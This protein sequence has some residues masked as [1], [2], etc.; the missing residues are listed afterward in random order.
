V[1][2][3]LETCLILMHVHVTSLRLEFETQ[4]FIHFGAGFQVRDIPHNVTES[5]RRSHCEMI[6][7][8][9]N[10]QH[11]ESFPVLLLY[12]AFA[13]SLKTLVKTS[14]TAKFSRRSVLGIHAMF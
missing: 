8:V 7:L 3:K 6:R 4:S 5:D 14:R 1:K 9:C 2:K 13:T 11:T 12:T 10:N